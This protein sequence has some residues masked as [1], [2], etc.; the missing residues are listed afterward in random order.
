MKSALPL[1]LLCLFVPAP[2]RADENTDVFRLGERRPLVMFVV[3]P[4]NT[5][6]PAG[7]D[8]VRAAGDALA[9]RT[10]LFVENAEQAGV[11]LSA[12]AACSA[13]E[14]LACYA[15]AV[16][17]TA[18]QRIRRRHLLVITLF[19]RPNQHHTASLSALLLDLDAA[20]RAQESIFGGDED[21]KQRLE[22]AIF[23]RTARATERTVDLRDPQK[24]QAYFEALFD[25][26]LRPMLEADFDPFGELEL[27]GAAPELELAIDGNVLGKTTGKKISIREVR[28]RKLEL[29]LS[30][31]R[32]RYLKLEREVNIVRG[33]RST[34]KIELVRAA[35]PGIAPQ[36]RKATFWG[37]V[38]L[39]VAGGVLATYAI[40]RAPSGELTQTC[41]GPECA[42]TGPSRSFANFCELSSD[43]PSRC[44]PGGIRAAPLGLSAMLSGGIFAA[45]TALFGEEAEIPWWPLAIGTV[46]GIASYGII[47]AVD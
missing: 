2:A 24:V 27:E 19:D 42:N 11:D 4:G 33:E 45:G 29:E 30:D 26:E 17:D 16:P 7:I 37:G 14:L 39:A 25:R 38:G 1:A 10:G 43:R 9:K 44:D 3:R 20:K 5:A 46:A 28:P 21:S 31:P 35:E 47:A 36:L 18:T 8:L 12:V 13:A 40:A 6:G 34:L 41:T 32:Q 15:R 22:D 23:E